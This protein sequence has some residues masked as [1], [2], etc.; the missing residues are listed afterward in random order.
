MNNRTDHL[1]RHPVRRLDRGIELARLGEPRLQPRRW[2]AES[3][4]SPASGSQGGSLL[5]PGEPDED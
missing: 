5:V 4:A 2:D 1:V 3:F